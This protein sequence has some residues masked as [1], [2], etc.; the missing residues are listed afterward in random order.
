MARLKNAYALIIGVGADLAQSVN[1]ANKVNNILTDESLAGYP[2]DNVYLLTEE[3][4]NNEEL[5]KAFAELKKRMDE[6]SSLFIY[7]SGHG[8]HYKEDLTEEIDGEI[9]PKRRKIKGEMITLQEDKYFLQMNGFRGYPEM[10]Y[11]EQVKHMFYSTELKE[12]LNALNTNSLVFFLDCCHARGMTIGGLNLGAKTVEIDDDGSSELEY[13]NVEGLA[14]K[15]DNEKGISIIS[16][17]REDQLSYIKADDDFSLFTSCLVEYISMRHDPDYKLPFIYIS[18]LSGHLQREVSRK[19]R[20]ELNP[21]EQQNPYVNLQNRDNFPICYSPLFIREKLGATAESDDEKAVASTSAQKDSTKDTP[22]ISW[23]NEGTD[24]LVIFVHGFSGEASGTFGQIP[25]M[26]LEDK[27][28]NGWDMRPFG[29]SQFVNPEMGKEVWAGIS[30]IDRIANEL[31]LSIIYKFNAYSRIA[32]VAHS[33]GGLVAQKALLSL[34][35]EHMLRVSHLVMYGTPSD[36]IDPQVLKNTWQE[37]YEAMSREGDFIKELRSSWTNSF[38]DGIP[39]KLKVAG[40]ISDEYVDL[41]SCFEPFEESNCE[42]IDGDH[43]RMVKPDSAD[44]ASYQLIVKTL[45]DSEFA[46]KYLNKEEVNLALGKY[47]VTV[48]T[49][50][51]QVEELGEEGLKQLIFGLEGLDRR[52]EALQILNTHPVAKGNSDL[53]GIIGGRHK[54]AYLLKN[55]KKDGDAAIE[56]YKKGLEIAQQ[57]KDHDQIYYLAINLAFTSIVIENDQTNMK[58]YAQ[59]ALD[60]TEHCVDDLWKI[61]TVGEA[62]MYLSDFD[63]AKENYEKAASMANIRQKISMHNNAYAGYTSLTKITDQDND[64]IKFLK[65]KFLM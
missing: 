57:K 12:S 20:E 17:C 37:K 41:S 10:E 31:K 55:L 54:R 34:K 4:A 51:P 22:V 13:D 46:N 29:Y 61:A 25:K 26:L 58:T 56:Y 2:E 23:R 64:F 32:I 38:K 52:E 60:A 8:G 48:Q 36:G 1:D 30:D 19:A 43:L 62:K 63:S 21:P 18:E 6:N 15:V 53:M 49:L 40:S 39:F 16:A 14:Q 7:Y 65:E 42:M 24:N 9:L 35:P 33:L 44:S 47:G 5:R 27:D 11:E 50:L 3:K 28:M 45:T 59:M